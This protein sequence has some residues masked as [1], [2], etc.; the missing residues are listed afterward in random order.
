MES[1]VARSAPLSPQMTGRVKNENQAL[2]H[3][4]LSATTSTNL[5]YKQPEQHQN[6]TG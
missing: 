2:V 6:C 5:S 3:A 4:E 1:D